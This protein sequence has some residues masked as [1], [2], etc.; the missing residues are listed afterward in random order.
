VAAKEN[1]KS[2]G[3]STLRVNRSACATKRKSGIVLGCWLG[4]V[5]LSLEFDWE[6]D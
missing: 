6:S 1:P 3:P 2:T 4:L 5:G